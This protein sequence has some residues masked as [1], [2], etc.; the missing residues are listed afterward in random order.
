MS[1]MKSVVLEEAEAIL[2]S[3]RGVWDED[4]VDD[5]DHALQSAHLA[6]ADGADDELILAA[7]LHDLGHSPL[8]TPRPDHD[9]VARL[10][11]TPRFGERVGWLAGA[12]VAAKRHLALTESGYLDALSDRSVDTLSA[13]GGQARVGSQWTSNPWWPDA[14]RLRRFDDAAKIPGAAAMTVAEVLDVAGRVVAA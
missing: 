2:W 4:A 7:A 5:L 3:L 11:L 1:G 8:L 9:R 12:H 13:Q 10:W 14:L 6:Q